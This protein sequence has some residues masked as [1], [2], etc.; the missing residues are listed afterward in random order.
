M[1]GASTVDS[2]VSPLLQYGILGIVVIIFGVVI[3]TLWREGKKEREDLLAAAKQER[4]ALVMKIIELQSARV[5]DAQH[6]QT[7]MVDVIKQCTEAVTN[8]SATLERTGEALTEMKNSLRD[9]ASEL[10]RGG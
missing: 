6:V 4:D 10:R 7:Q 8:V 3:Y 5:A 1:Q 2:V 9:V